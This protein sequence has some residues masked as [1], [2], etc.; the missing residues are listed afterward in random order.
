M[1]TSF[2]EKNNSSRT[3]GGGLPL[4]PTTLR[5]LHVALGEISFP[6]HTTPLCEATGNVLIHIQFA[7]LTE[8][9]QV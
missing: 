9:K 6:F 1:C 5:W 4:R 3:R 8:E 7:R 2:F